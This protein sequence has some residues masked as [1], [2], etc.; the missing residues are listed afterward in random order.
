MENP[1][2]FLISESS[3]EED[4]PSSDS[5]EEREKSD[6]DTDELYRLAQAADDSSL[7][8]DDYMKFFRKES[9]KL[10]NKLN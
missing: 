5:E 4:S 8:A 2:E 3:E 7:M 9:Q 1:L 6:S 10:L